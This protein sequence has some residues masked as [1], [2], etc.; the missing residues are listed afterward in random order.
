MESHVDDVD[1]NHESEDVDEGSLEWRQVACH[2]C[3]VLDVEV[4]NEIDVRN[5][6]SLDVGCH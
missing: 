1:W 5:E 4:E 6:L 2:P 3:E